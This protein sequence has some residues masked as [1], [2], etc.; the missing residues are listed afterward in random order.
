MNM[1][2]VEAVVVGIGVGYARYP[3]IPKDEVRLS[4]FSS[5]LCNTDL[6]HGNNE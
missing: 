5:Y 4:P 3:G 6:S 2:G 1:Y